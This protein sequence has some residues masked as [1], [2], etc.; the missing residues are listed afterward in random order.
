MDLKHQNNKMAAGAAAKKAG[1]KPG[2]LTQ[3]QIIMKF[4]QM[5]QEQR[6]VVNKVGRPK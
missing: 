3:E 5:R 6:I 4:N 2:G 1:G